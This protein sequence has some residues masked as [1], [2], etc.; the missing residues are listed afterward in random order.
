MA[1]YDVVFFKPQEVTV[2]LVDG[3]YVVLKPP[4][5]TIQALNARPPADQSAE[6]AALKA[7]VTGLEAELAACLE[8][9]EEPPPLPPPTITTGWQL[10]DGESGVTHAKFSLSAAIP[11]RHPGGDWVDAD[12]VAQGTMPYANLTL[13]GSHEVVTA[14]TFDVTS[15]KSGMLFV[16]GVGGPVK[17]G[18]RENADPALRPVLTL[19]MADGS[20]VQAPCVAS[21]V[22][23]ASTFK[24]V[25]G[26]TASVGSGVN[27]ALQFAM[28]EGEWT[29]AVLT[30]TAVRLFGN[31]T[32]SVYEI[33]PPTALATTPV[34]GLASAYPLDAGIENDPDVYFASSLTDPA[35]RLS[36][37][38]EHRLVNSE[39]RNDGNDGVDTLHV[40]YETNDYT[41]MVLN[42]RWSYKKTALPTRGPSGLQI[43]EEV[44]ASEYGPQQHPGTPRE[45]YFR[46]YFKL[47]PGYQC[48]VEGKK[49][50][51]LA[52]RYGKWNSAGYYQY[53]AGNGGS[54][55]RGTYTATDGYSGWSMRCIAMV[56]AQIPG[57]PPKPDP[58][59][60][61]AQRVPLMTYAYHVN[62]PTNYGETWRWGSHKFGWPLLEES[63][64]RW[65]CIEQHVVINSV[66]G[67]FD[68]LGNGTGV[69]DGV[70]EAWLDGVKVFEK[71]DVVFTKHPAI[72][73]D[74]VWLDHY[75]GGTALPEEEHGFAMAALVVARK[76]IGPMESLMSVVP[77]LGLSFGL[78]GSPAPPPA[79]PDLPLW[80]PATDNTMA[81]I[82]SYIGTSLASTIPAYY[83][84]SKAEEQFA[85]SGRCGNKDFGLYGAY[86]QC[87]GGHSA[88]NYSALST[89]AFNYATVDWVRHT[90]PYDFTGQIFKDGLPN[91]DQGNAAALTHDFVGE[92]PADQASTI[93]P[94]SMHSYDIC[95]V[96]PPDAGG[97]ANGTF[98]TVSRA[99]IGYAGSSPQDAL[100]AHKVDLTDTTGPFEWQ[101]A[102]VLPSVSPINQVGTAAAYDPTRD[103][104]WH[105]IAANANNARIDYLNVS[106]GTRGFTNYTGPQRPLST[107]ASSVDL[108]G[109]QYEPAH[110]CLIH[111]CGGD[112]GVATIAYMACTNP[113]SGWTIPTLTGD[114]IVLGASQA[115]ALPM[116][117]V[118]PLGQW[119]LF[120]RG[121]LTHAYYITIPATITDAW[122]VE[123]VAWSGI[124]LFTFYVIG[125]PVYFHA[126]RCIV[127]VKDGVVVY[128]YR[129]RGV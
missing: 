104:M 117:W 8:G 111:S 5:Y 118:E 64:T 128:A 67:P 62:M 107:G 126:T 77:A 35:Q 88:T 76:Y 91:N 129:P 18:R 40:H 109:M 66:V 94:G 57:N 73:I 12:G 98:I 120:S 53:T 108:G 72:G 20:I 68:T 50:P 125:K 86:H 70:L 89:L 37:F 46:C 112:N 92:Y 33:H 58:G 24:G 105:T 44:P 65:Y 23:D 27:L 106:D 17:V 101:R 69:P 4:G 39:I 119:I 83:S 28:P 25:V 10:W 60:P 95:A 74:E 85:F 34:M 122:T 87:G 90:T 38:P 51:G 13:P 82:S 115:S 116:V 84:A 56:G 43:R 123:K 127:W 71:R 61:Y 22:T 9:E 54:P 36:L 29:K 97:A 96:K 26:P 59:N 78:V 2:R 79:E 7:R 63:D 81:D 41:P 52:G 99:A 15:I 114:S 102:S 49:L 21:G 1:F 47:K 14:L 31:C 113:A 75:H 3:N 11:W 121:D 103:R 93:Q 55:T 42:H 80:T 32:L 110:D 30:L 124:P 6:I 45:M 16:V 19:T 100:M 48:H